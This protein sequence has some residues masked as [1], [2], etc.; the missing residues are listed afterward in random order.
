[1]MLHLQIVVVRAEE[2]TMGVWHRRG[3]GAVY[4][5]LALWWVQLGLSIRRYGL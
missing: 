4:L 3:L 1:M 5:G 2:R